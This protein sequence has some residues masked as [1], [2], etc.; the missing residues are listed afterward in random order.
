MVVAKSSER[1]PPERY[2]KVD[3]RRLPARLVRSW[4]GS[5]FLLFLV[6]KLLPIPW[7]GP[8][9]VPARLAVDRVAEESADVQLRS[10]MGP[11]LSA[12]EPLGFRM[13]FLYSVRTLGSPRGLAGALLSADDCSVCLL[14][15]VAGPGATPEA[16][17]SLLSRTTSGDLLGTSSG[18]LRLPPVPDVDVVRLPDR[19]VAA[20]ATHHLERVRTRTLRPFTSD[21]IVPLLQR[22]H[23]RTVA[24][25]V[26]TGLYVEATA[27]DVARMR[28]RV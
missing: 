13:A 23:E 26:S 9:L 20:V 25:Y 5:G 22:Q 3:I 14:L 7:Y 16:S 10:M 28:V 17:M 18:V 21:E 24:H 11:G 19:P 6:R 1:E 15:C 8:V 27:A 12:V 4:G 2:Y